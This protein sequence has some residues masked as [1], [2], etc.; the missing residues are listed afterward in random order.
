MGKARRAHASC[1]PGVRSPP[2]ARAQQCPRPRD[3]TVKEADRRDTHRP[4]GADTAEGGGR[5]V[6]G[7]TKP[8]MHQIDPGVT[9]TLPVARLSL[10]LVRPLVKWLGDKTLEPRH[11]CPGPSPGHTGEVT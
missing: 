3:S 7:N 5:W 11:L 6:Q 9:N 10:T 8:R 4:L 2:R 1:P